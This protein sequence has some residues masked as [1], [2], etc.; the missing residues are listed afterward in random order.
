MPTDIGMQ[1][2][3]HC[4]EYVCSYVDD[5]TAIM[6]DPQAFF[7]EL[8]RCGF[9]LKGVMAKPEVFLGGSF[10]RDPDGTLFWGAKCYIA[11]AMETY[12]RMI[13]AQPKIC[14]T[15]LP[16]KSHLELDTTTKLDEQGRIKYQSLIRC[17]QWVVLLV[18]LMWHAL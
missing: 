7:D 18:G 17:L 11:R 13:G 14:T 3:G 15:P 12:K 2:A 5:L 9:G 16:E 1:D 8:K 10:G 4:Y 6:V